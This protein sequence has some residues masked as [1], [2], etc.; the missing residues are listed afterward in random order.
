[1]NSCGA[2][3]GELLHRHAATSQEGTGAA[4]VSDCV[5]AYGCSPG[6]KSCL[7]EC[8]EAHKK[9]EVIDRKSTYDRKV[10]IEEDRYYFMFLTH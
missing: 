2:R 9:H 10:N 4:A 7:R 5:L 3:H 6:D 8:Y 1:M